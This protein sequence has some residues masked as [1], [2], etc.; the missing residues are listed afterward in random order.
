MTSECSLDWS[1]ETK[2]RLD[3]NI[4]DEERESGIININRTITHLIL[5]DLKELGQGKSPLIRER[6]AEDELLDSKLFEICHVTYSFD[7][8][9]DFII[10]MKN[11]FFY[12]CTYSIT[13]KIADKDSLTL[14]EVQ[15]LTETLKRCKRGSEISEEIFLGWEKLFCLKFQS[16]VVQIKR[17]NEFLALTITPG[18]DENSGS[19]GY[20]QRLS[21]MQ[22]DNSNFDP[23][24]VF[25]TDSGIFS[26]IIEHKKNL[27]NDIESYSLLEGNALFDVLSFA[28]LGGKMDKSMFLLC[29]AELRNKYNL[30]KVTRK[31]NL[32]I[33]QVRPTTLTEAESGLYYTRDSNVTLPTLVKGKMNYYFMGGFYRSDAVFRKE[34]YRRSSHKDHYW[35]S[36]TRSDN[37][38]GGISTVWDEEVDAG[39]LESA[40]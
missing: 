15:A 23:V 21:F 16:C 31:E 11:W 34:E 22:M 4:L 7:K 2:K 17:A 40:S 18:L 10:E 26:F 25:H 39:V 24:L 27:K 28:E 36:T 13:V 30:V 29:S 38:H 6:E 19:S 33:A 35:F 9:G 20:I 12:S 14:K 3:E 1:S 5:E 37:V 8:N 32:L